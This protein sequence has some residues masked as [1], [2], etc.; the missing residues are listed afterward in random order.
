M[1]KILF[2]T[3][4]SDTANNAFLYALKMAD[5]LN[6]E[7]V[8]LHAYEL[9][10]INFDGNLA[11]APEIYSSIEL[12][13]FNN[14]KDILPK[15]KSIASKNKL[16]HIQLKHMLLH[17]NL[18]D[19]MKEVVKDEN[20]RLIV[21]GTS[22]ELDW[23]KRLFGSNVLDVMNHVPQNM[24]AIPEKASYQKIKTIGF[25]TKFREKDKKALKEVIRIAN[26]LEANVK[27][28][29][30]K[31]KGSDVTEQII[32]EWRDKYKAKNVQFVIIPHE[33]VKESIYDFMNFNHVDVLAMLSYK[34]NFLSDVFIKRN[35]TKEIVGEIQIPLLT[36]RSDYRV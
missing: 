8:V 2:P 19:T 11:F 27:C 36:I 10:V 1:K 14:F 24:M 12:D 17:G 26:R 28:L 33:D 30:V 22:G 25:T 35:L 13:T 16:D 4:F 29:Y 32:N 3:D 34:S 18:V 7:L 15:L 9:P 5:Y 6:Y 21:M 31:T 20:I 23:A